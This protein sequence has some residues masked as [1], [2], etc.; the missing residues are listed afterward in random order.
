MAFSPAPSTIGLEFLVPTRIKYRGGL[1]KEIDFQILMRNL[2]RRIL[3]LCELH[4]GGGVEIDYNRLLRKAET[5]K[6][7]QNELRW[8]DWE[9]WSSRQKTWMK[10]G[11]F[12]GRITF[13]GDLG[14]FIPFIRLGEYIHIGK[15]TSFG[16]GKYR[17]LGVSTD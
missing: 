1:T 5:I 7:V 10:L 12:V 2:L 9:R 3:L 13:E 6:T 4:C 11:G 14:E 15:G 8:H 17:T 16:L